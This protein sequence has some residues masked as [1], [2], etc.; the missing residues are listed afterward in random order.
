MINMDENQKNALCSAIRTSRYSRKVIALLRD[1][2][3]DLFKTDSED[4]MTSME[5]SMDED[6]LNVFSGILSDIDSGSPMDAEQRLRSVIEYIRG[7]EEISFVIPIHP[8]KQMVRR[9]HDWCSQN[10]RRDILMDFTVNRLMESGVLM[11]YKGH[12]FEYSLE[13]LLDEYF[14]THNMDDYVKQE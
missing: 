2:A 3:D 10:I 5:H 9:L 6:L 13:N 11:I 4:L 7:L 12:Y 1:M 14:S 8:N